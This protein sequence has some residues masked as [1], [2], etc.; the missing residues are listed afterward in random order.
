MAPETS[1]VTTADGVHIA[2]Q[3]VGLGPSDVVFVPGFVFNVEHLWETT[4]P[5][6]AAFVRKLATFSRV[7][8]FDRR[9]TGLSDRIAKSDASLT[10]EARM[11]DI[12]AVMDAAGSS[13]ATLLTFEDGLAL[14]A[15][16]AATFRE[17]TTALVSYGGFATARWAPDYPWGWTE[18]QLEELYD[19]M[20]TG[21]GTIEFARW[22]ARW[23]W[24][25]LDDEKW[26]AEYATWMRRS[27]SPGDAAE[28]Y[29][30]DAETDIRDLLPSIL[31]P[32]LIIH[33]VDDR[34]EAVEQARYLADR[35]PGA[36]LVELPGSNHNWIAPDQDEVLDVIE[37]F[38]RALHEEEASFDRV[39]ATVLFTDI[40]GSTETAARLGDQ[41]W[42]AAVERHHAAVRGMLA[43]YRGTEVDTAGDGFFAS[44]DGPARAVRCACAIATSVRELGLEVRAGVHT[45]EVEVID[46]KIGGITVTVGARIADAAAPSEVLVSRTVKDL[47]AGSGLAFEDVG[48]HELRGVPDRWRL[49]RAV[50][51]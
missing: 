47:V 32:T 40:V 24:P 9:G 3:V 30:I 34:A 51:T 33:R 50:S 43:R 25:T 14:C 48:E 20:R 26:I 12:R 36:E 15:L 10:L 31:V 22:F 29:R 11:G 39:L 18:A 23:D 28:L 2:Y 4:W 27:V 17:R 6:P 7:I 49:Y 19:R 42:R 13:R 21:W 41:A 8:L 37:R 5:N 35:I 38:V 1:Y 44:F 46:Q 16:F 45:G